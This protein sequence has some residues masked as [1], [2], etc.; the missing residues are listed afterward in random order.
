[1][2]KVFSILFLMVMLV[3]STH[4]FWLNITF[5][6]N[7][8][9][10][11]ASHCENKAKP[12]LHCDGN[13]HLKKEIDKENNQ[14]SPINNAKEKFE[15]LFFDEVKNWKRLVFIEKQ[16]SSFIYKEVQYTEPSFSIIHPPA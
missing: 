5:H 3:Y 15:V 16:L 10:I 14:K 7:Q 9:E 8:E 11:A 4:N 13:C 1:M 2:K 12:K 6:F